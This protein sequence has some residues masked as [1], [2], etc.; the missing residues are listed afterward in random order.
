MIDKI[1]IFLVDI[2]SDVE[3]FLN[4]LSN[5]E[6]TLPV[7]KRV[8]D[9]N[10]TF[11]W[12]IYNDNIEKLRDQLIKLIESKLNSIEGEILKLFVNQGSIND[13]GTIEFEI[14]NGCIFEIYLY[15]QEAFTY[16]RIYQERRLDI[17][18]NQKYELLD[19]EWL[20]IDIDYVNRSAWFLD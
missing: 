17:K 14:V 16:I 12:N 6:K 1:P 20:S 8:R 4:T 5:R 19:N 11:S 3:S 10:T 18:K 2:I 9:N 7:K 13:S 15:R